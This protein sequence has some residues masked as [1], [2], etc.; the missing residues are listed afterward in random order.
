[1]SA[2]A[3]PIPWLLRQ[4]K[5]HQAIEERDANAVAD[6]AGILKEKTELLTNPIA[7][8]KKESERRNSSNASRT[9]CRK[10]RGG[11][12]KKIRERTLRLWCRDWKNLRKF[13]SLQLQTDQVNMFLQHSLQIIV[14]SSGEHERHTNLAANRT[15]RLPKIRLSLFPFQHCSFNFYSFLPLKNAS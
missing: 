2:L 12:L 15:I 10:K 11:R 14:T 13:K 8:E 1:M 9:G 4:Y 5:R 3:P 7:V 6:N